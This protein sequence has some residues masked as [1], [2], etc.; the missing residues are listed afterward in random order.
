VLVAAGALGVWLAV[1]AL[2]LGLVVVAALADLSGHD[3]G[4]SGAASRQGGRRIWSGEQMANAQ[5]IISTVVQ[6]GLPRRAAVVAVATAIAESGLRNLPAGDRDSL[7]LF[8]QRPSQGWGR[9][10]QILDPTQATNQFLDHL[11]ALPRWARL[12]P[13]VAE[14]LIQRSAHPAAY[15]PQ[16]AP[17]DT[18]VTQYWTNPTSPTPPVDNGP[19]RFAAFGLTTCPGPDATNPPRHPPAGRSARLPAGYTPPSDPSARTA[20]TYALAQ[21]AKPY[22]WGATGP[23]AFDCSG[24]VQASWAAAGIPIGRTT[25]AQI[26]DGAPVTSLTQL[27]PGDLLF[28]PGD[29]GTPAHPRHVGLYVGAGLVIDAFDSHKGVITESLARWAPKVAAIRRVTIPPP[30][31]PPSAR[32]RAGRR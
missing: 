16:E 25:S 32:S 30:P 20:L 17:A 8:Q 22:V 1:P 7:G 24:L 12:A 4:D 13:G 5:R 2:V 6:R 9:P 11:V 29:E 10:A 26:H 14:Q 21:V 15:T 3:C 19:L 18:L 27:Q 28:I 23:N 31:P